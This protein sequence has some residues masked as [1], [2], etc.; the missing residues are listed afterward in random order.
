VSISP[1]V[2]SIGGTVITAQV[3]GATVTSTDI[4]IKD[5]SGNSICE[6]I[7]VISYGVVE[8]KTKA[9]LIAA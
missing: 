3:P 4:D 2:G 8:C 5:P 7:A 9:Q 6:T 1:N